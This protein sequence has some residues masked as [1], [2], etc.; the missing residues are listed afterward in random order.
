MVPHPPAPPLADLAFTEDLNR[1]RARNH[2]WD[3]LSYNRIHN[4][5]DRLVIR[6]N[7]Y[8]AAE[9]RGATSGI[10]AL[11]VPSIPIRS[12]KS[13]RLSEVSNRSDAKEENPAVRDGSQKI[14][15][16][17]DV[18]G[19][20]RADDVSAWGSVSGESNEPKGPSD[21]SRSKEKGKV[22]PVDKKAEKK[23]ITAKAKAKL[24]AGR[25]PAFRIVE[26]L[27]FF[28]LKHPLLKVWVLRFLL[29]LLSILTA[30]RSRR[31]Q[32]FKQLLIFLIILFPVFL[33]SL[34]RPD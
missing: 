1:L 28:R 24:E 32:L 19:M 22:D 25:I 16:A 20:Q 34:R 6:N 18:T 26:L 11:N 9:R 4:V 27:K 33:L 10:P 29:L 17:T 21:A 5:R 8:W 3:D 12:R 15:S 14:S 31:V 2:R 23:R 30:W 13:W 7:E